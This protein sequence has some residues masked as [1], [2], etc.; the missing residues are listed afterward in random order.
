MATRRKLN[1]SAKEADRFLASE[2]R[3]MAKE[4]STAQLTLVRDAARALLARIDNLT[5]DEFQLGGERKEREALRAALEVS[6]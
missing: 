6:A 3:R 5:T 4:N 2:T 1:L